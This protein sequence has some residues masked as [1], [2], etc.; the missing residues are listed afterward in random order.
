MPFAEWSAEVAQKDESGRPPA[1]QLG[2][3]DNFSRDVEDLRVWCG[4][5]YA[6]LIHTDF[7]CV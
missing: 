1:P 5:S 3:R 4:V 6:R 2:Q 7:V